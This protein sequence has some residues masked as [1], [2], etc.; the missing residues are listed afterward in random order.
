MFRQERPRMT[1][2]RKKLSIPV[3]VEEVI[4]DSQGNSLKPTGWVLDRTIKVSV[5]EYTQEELAEL[6]LAILDYLK[7]K[8]V[9]KPGRGWQDYIFVNI[10]IDIFKRKEIRDRVEQLKQHPL[11]AGLAVVYGKILDHIT[12]TDNEAK[13]VMEN[14]SKK[15]KDTKAI[16]N[17]KLFYKELLREIVKLKKLNIDVESLEDTDIL[18]TVAEELKNTLR[19]Q[20]DSKLRTYVE[21][22]LL[23]LISAGIFEIIKYALSTLMYRAPHPEEQI[24]EVECDVIRKYNKWNKVALRS[25]QDMGE[26]DIVLLDLLVIYILHALCVL[27]VL[28]LNVEGTPLFQTMPKVDRRVQ[29]NVDSLL[30]DLRHFF[31]KS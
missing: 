18:K 26:I 29:K 1:K 17:G 23:G 31:E 2:K 22:I 10:V 27:S 7:R 8:N 24:Y 9:G 5:D 4:S 15:G 6:A 13:Q 3:S 16:T 25:L 30:S 12:L 19:K 21:A 28:G 20:N 11:I 14:V